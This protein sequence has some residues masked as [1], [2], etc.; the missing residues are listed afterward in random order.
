MRAFVKACTAK[1]LPA[2]TSRPLLG[3]NMVV[4]AQIR[5]NLAARQIDD[6]DVL[7]L[8]RC[9]CWSRQGQADTVVLPAMAEHVLATCPTAQASCYDGVGHMPHLEDPARYNHELA[10]L[11]RRVR[12]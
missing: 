3:R 11:S 1:P 6:D 9:R 12:A 7:P 10:D 8:S 4:P 5:A 2:A